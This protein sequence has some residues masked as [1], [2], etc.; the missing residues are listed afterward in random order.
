[1]IMLKFLKSKIKKIVKPT[2]GLGFPGDGK[3][4][5]RSAQIEALRALKVNENFINKFPELLFCNESYFSLADKVDA[6]KVIEE[7]IQSTEQWMNYSDQVPSLAGWVDSRG[8][9]FKN[10]HPAIKYIVEIFK[11]FQPATVLDIGAGAGVV[12]KY[13]FASMPETKITCLE[14]SERHILEMKENFNESDIIPPKIKVQANIVKGIA[15]RMPFVDRSFEFVFTCTV[16]MHNPFIPGVLAACEIARVSSRYILHVE[17]YHTDGVASFRTP[18]NLRVYDYERLYNLLGFQ[19]K[20]KFFYQD[21]YAKD[22]DY[23]VF[24]AERIK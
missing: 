12:S 19:T 17:G 24:L 6:A 23:I 10:P 8:H 1:L 11:E 5:Q 13:I 16:M 21:P 15:Q 9:D 22:Y 7:Y 20:K 2:R 14:G 18:E 3:Q 4:R